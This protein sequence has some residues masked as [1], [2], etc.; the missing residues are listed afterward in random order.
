VK[1]FLK[2]FV[3]NILKEKNYNNWEKRARRQKSKLV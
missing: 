2:S 1:S 3:R